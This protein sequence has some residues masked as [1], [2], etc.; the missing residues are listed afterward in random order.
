MARRYSMRQGNLAIKRKAGNCELCG[1]FA[2]LTKIRFGN[3]YRWI[4]GYCKKSFETGIVHK[5][6]EQ[7]V[8]NKNFKRMIEKT[9][10]TYKKIR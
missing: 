1:T 3:R 9:E 6:L 2:G 7:K 10:L 5:K 8:F 4:C